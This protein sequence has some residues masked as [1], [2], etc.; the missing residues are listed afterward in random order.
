LDLS[1]PVLLH[2][3][4]ITGIIIATS[5]VLLRNALPAVTGTKIL[6][7]AASMLFGRPVNFSL[8][9]VIAPVEYM[10]AATMKSAPM[11]STPELAK[12]ARLRSSG[13]RR[14]VMQRVRAPRKTVTGGSF[15]PSRAAN[16]AAR[17]PTVSQASKLMRHPS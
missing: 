10:P 14:R 12:P 7:W 13:A 9:R 4:R 8:N 17:M 2:K 6:S 11:V 5:G 16:V 1:R 15:V 3:S